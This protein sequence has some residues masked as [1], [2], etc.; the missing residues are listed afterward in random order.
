MP[1]TIRYDD[2]KDSTRKSLPA[3][4]DA[5][6]FQAERSEESM[7]VDQR[8]SLRPAEL[9]EQKLRNLLQNKTLPVSFFRTTAPGSTRHHC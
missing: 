2:R 5:Y 1:A 9:V 4:L 3:S 6:S 8:S 7:V